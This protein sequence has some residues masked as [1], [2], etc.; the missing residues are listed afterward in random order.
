LCIFFL[1]KLIYYFIDSGH[2]V[3][4]YQIFLTTILIYLR[5]G[6]P[7]RNDVVLRGSP[8]YIQMNRILTYLYLCN[9]LKWGI[10]ALDH[11]LHIYSAR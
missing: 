1:I 5:N 3:S 8:L 10:F 7:I 4:I 2:L 6:V 9:M 11:Q